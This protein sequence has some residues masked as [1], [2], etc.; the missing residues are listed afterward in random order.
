M[1]E[2][3]GNSRQP[4]SASVAALDASIEPLA[5][6]LPAGTSEEQTASLREHM[7]DFYAQREG[8]IL[9][10]LTD[11]WRGN[12]GWSSI[13]LNPGWGAG[14]SLYVKGTIALNKPGYAYR[15]NIMV[16]SS[17][18][19]D[20]LVW[21]YP[22]TGSLNGGSSWWDDFTMTVPTMQKYG[23]SLNRAEVYVGNNTWCYTLGPHVDGVYPG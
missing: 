15:T 16:F 13:T 7:D 23:A 11:E 21:N 9:P 18:A 1:Q 10:A 22:E 3:E 2:V 14:Y 12:C 17:A 19:T 6:Q 8:Q 20:F 4:S 5:V